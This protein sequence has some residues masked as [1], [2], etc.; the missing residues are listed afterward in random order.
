VSS[1]SGFLVSL[2]SICLTI[3]PII[4]VESRL[5]FAAKIIGVVLLANGVGAVLFHLGNRRAEASPG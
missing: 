1:I 4:S 5:L 2:L 3:V